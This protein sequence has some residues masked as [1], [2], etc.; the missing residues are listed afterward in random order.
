[1]IELKAKGNQGECYERRLVATVSDSAS[2]A[3]PAWQQNRAFRTGRGPTTAG[4]FYPVA[5][6][7]HRPMM[8]N[9]V[10][11]APGTLWTDR[12]EVAV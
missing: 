8:V 11:E 9:Q 7:W 10:L 12:G 1:M 3:C 2:G 4:P 6:G 5:M